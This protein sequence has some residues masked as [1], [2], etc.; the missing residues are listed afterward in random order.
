MR[1]SR[2]D[3]PDPSLRAYPAGSASPA[4]VRFR[5]AVYGGAFD[6]PHPG[7]E[8]VVRRVLERA[9]QVLLVPSHRHAHGKRMVDF[10]LRCAW[11]ERLAARID[12]AR[13]RCDPIEARLAPGAAAV[14]SYD[15]LQALAAEHGVM[16]EDI[17]LVIGEDNLP[18]VAGFHRGAELRERFGLLVADETLLLHSSAI[19]LHLREGLALPPAWCLP[20]VQGEL[21]IYRELQ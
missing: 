17:A 12:P 13:V 21:D 14:Y 19:R 5:L 8:S 15:L 20:E 4:P 18:Q 3:F 10:A 2:Q 6:P 7:H 1:N 11:L 9:E 16:P